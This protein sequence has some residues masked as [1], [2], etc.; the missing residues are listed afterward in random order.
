MKQQHV[1]YDWDAKPQYDF[2][3]KI[4]LLAQ[5]S[6]TT[7]TT[8][9]T[10]WT[11]T[12]TM[13]FSTL[14]AFLFLGLHRFDDAN[15]DAEGGGPLVN[16]TIDIPK[17]LDVTKYCAPGTTIKG[18]MAKYKLVGGIVYD[19]DDYVAI[20]KN[21]NI[22]TTT[23][24]TIQSDKDDDDNDQDEEIEN[25]NLLETEEV[26]PMTETDVMEFLKGEDGGVCGTVLVYATVHEPSHKEMNQLL[27]DIIISH[28][29]GKLDSK[30][31][32]YYEE[33]WIEEEILED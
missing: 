24:T 30:A 7:S 6:S 31:D 17:E 2:E 8:E 12:K 1:K 5:S 14:P 15:D 3:V 29:S 19:E 32:F 25:W 28:V 21:P 11:T 26:I 4:P 16:P 27:S 10:K 20:L 23:T 22:T 9:E 18:N 33:E 13:Q